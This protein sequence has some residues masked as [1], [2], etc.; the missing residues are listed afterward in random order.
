MNRV[1]GNVSWVS[2]GLRRELGS[3]VLIRGG[4]REAFSTEAH[5]SE[6]IAVY[7]DPIRS[8]QV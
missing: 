1:L 2:E 3:G 7:K 4:E 8:N 5:P 6:V